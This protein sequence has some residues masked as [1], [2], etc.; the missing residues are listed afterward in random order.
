METFDGIELQSGNV[1]TD[2]SI[3][4][5]IRADRQFVVGSEDSTFPAYGSNGSAGRLTVRPICRL[6]IASEHRKIEHT[7]TQTLHVRGRVCVDFSRHSRPGWRAL[8]ARVG[9]LSIMVVGILSAARRRCCRR[10]SVR[11]VGVVRSVYVCDMTLSIV[12]KG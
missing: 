4:S 3:R 1:A 6:S 11:S 9:H 5:G 2:L 8:R 7:R 12:Q 10:S